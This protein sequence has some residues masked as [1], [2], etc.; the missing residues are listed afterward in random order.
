MMTQHHRLLSVYVN[1]LEIFDSF[2][3]W[4]QGTDSIHD[5]CVMNTD[6]A[7]YQSKTPKKCM[8]TTESEKKKKYINACLN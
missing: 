8:E 7:S 3:K 6:A 1:Y 2:I 5:I 4:N